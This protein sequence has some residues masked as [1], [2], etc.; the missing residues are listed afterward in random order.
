MSNG[1][2][3]RSTSASYDEDGGFAVNSNNY[4][5]S[6]PANLHH[7]TNL[8][9]H[10][11]PPHYQS[12]QHIGN[13]S[14]TNQPQDLHRFA[15]NADRYSNSSQGQGATLMGNGG[16]SQNANTVSAVNVSVV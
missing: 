9:S 5:G 15:Q 13:Y 4:A 10:Q 2:R 8:V 11:Q 6:I 14:Y 16:L 3:Q 12:S 7:S 1:Y